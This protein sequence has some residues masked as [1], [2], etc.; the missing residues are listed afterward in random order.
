MSHNAG[1][2]LSPRSALGLGG[3]SLGLGLSTIGGGGSSL[4]TGSGYLFGQDAPQ[5]H[6][7]S[8]A[9][10]LSFDEVASNVEQDQRDSIPNVSTPEPD[11]DD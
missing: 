1:S 9:R 11:S 3:G 5:Q 6:P 8:F 4:N 7:R 10:R 2:S